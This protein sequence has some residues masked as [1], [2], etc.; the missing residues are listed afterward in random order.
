MWGYH[1]SLSPMCRSHHG[2]FITCRPQINAQ[3]LE[4]DLSIC[5]PGAKLSTSTR[6]TLTGLTGKDSAHPLAQSTRA[7][8]VTFAPDEIALMAVGP[9][10]AP[11]HMSPARQEDAGGPQGSP[12]PRA[13][14]SGHRG[15]SESPRFPLLALET[16]TPRDQ[17]PRP[18]PALLPRCSAAFAAAR[19]RAIPLV[20]TSW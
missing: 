14:G 13:G 6:T 1:E 9:P 15:P 2:L 10:P 19:E 4:M 8:N 16:R 3:A 18:C 20:K 7:V 12:A 11:P 5:N 17:Q